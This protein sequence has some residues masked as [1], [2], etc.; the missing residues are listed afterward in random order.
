M[1]IVLRVLDSGACSFTEGETRI[2]D[3]ANFTIGRGEENDWVV[4]DPQRHLSKQHCRIELRGD[5]YYIVDTSTNGVFIGGAAKPL[6]R[7]NAQALQDGDEINLGPCCLRLEIGKADT[8]TFDDVQAPIDQMPMDET[9]MAQMSGQRASGTGMADQTTESATPVSR[10]LS[11]NTV[12]E[13][14]LAAMLAERRG[15]I[16]EPAF[17]GKG[18]RP[19]FGRDP[20]EI[21]TNSPATS[22]SFAL[23]SVAHS[24]IPTD[25]DRREAN[26]FGVADGAIE[27]A[28]VPLPSPPH[29]PAA[30]MPAQ[31]ADDLL[32]CFLRG[33]GLP[34]D[35]IETADAAAMMEKLGLAFR[36]AVGGLRE[37]L[38]LRAFLKS[39]FRIEHT[40]LRAKENNPMKFSANLDGTLSVLLGRRVPG[41]MGAPE[42]IRESM[43]DVKAHE[44]ALIA[45]MKAVV[46]DVLEQLSPEVVKSSVGT[47]VLPQIYKARCW[48]KYEQIHQ[49]LSGDQ[50]SGPPLG[51]QFSEAYS[52]QFRNM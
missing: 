23:P 15:A 30:E 20:I 2:C 32:S 6:G 25:W 39:E 38:E 24:T 49:R 51:S 14:P 52:K 31:P 7:G 47:T 42:A 36:E 10:I 37:L 4:N 41:F 26:S 11:G 27:E 35:A 12:L 45:G 5:T 29:E 43:R 8:P 40:L 1:A 18:P 28:Q 48:E 16:A 50:A 44:V 33:A 21:E 46:G 17:G 13:L 22:A 9:P 19:A 3:G 34:P